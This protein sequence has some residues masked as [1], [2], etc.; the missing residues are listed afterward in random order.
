MQSAPCP[1]PALY[2]GPMKP[3]LRAAAMA[4]NRKLFE[5]PGAEVAAARASLAASGLWQAALTVL[6]TI[7]LADEFPVLPLADLAVQQGKKLGLPLLSGKSMLFVSWDGSAGTLQPGNFGIPAPVNGAPVALAG[8][9]L[10]LVPGLA[11][12]ADAH[13]LGRGGGYY[14][15]FIAWSRQAQ[16]GILFA[17]LCLEAQILGD[18]PVEEH[19]MQ[20]DFLVTE[21]RTVSNIAD[22]KYI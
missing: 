16:T 11:F 2:N 3:Q 14:D 21:A 12:S 7:S 4:R 20:L 17:G 5:N 6:L 8:T 15:R 22:S 18:I 1:R 9:V 13:R 19:D 10:C